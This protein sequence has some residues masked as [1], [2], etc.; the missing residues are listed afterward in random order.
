VLN[1][2][3]VHLES[4]PREYRYTRYFF[5]NLSADIRG[6]FCDACDLLSIRWSQSSAKNISIADRRSVALLDTFVGPKR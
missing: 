3:T 6:I 4:G 5:T 1:R 2:F